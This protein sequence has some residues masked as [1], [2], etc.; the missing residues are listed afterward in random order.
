MENPVRYGRIFFLIV[1][2]LCLFELARL[3]SIT[4]DT[5][6]AHFNLQ[7]SPDRFVPKA[8][9]FRFQVQTLLVV[10]VVSLP[11]QFL[12]R[13]LPAGLINMPNRA[14]WLAPA[15]KTETLEQINSF[16]A[17]LF[18]IILLAIQAAFEISVYANL[19]TPILFNA[20]LMTAVMVAAVILILLMLALLVLSFRLPQDRS[21]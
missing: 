5:M 10:I 6:A 13:L 18:G 4:P 14:Y 3:W 17:V 2:A 20:S 15:R 21:L 1:L 12:F 7:G 9:F 19:R 11:F 8:E 16:G